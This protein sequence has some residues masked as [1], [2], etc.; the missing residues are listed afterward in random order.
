MSLQLTS[1]PKFLVLPHRLPDLLLHWLPPT[2]HGNHR[3]H[4]CD[5][6][7]D[8][9]GV[10][11]REVSA[12]RQIHFVLLLC[13]WD[14]IDWLLDDGGG[15]WWVFKWFLLI[16][17]VLIIINFSHLKSGCNENDNFHCLRNGTEVLDW[18]GYKLSRDYVYL[19]YL[20]MM[21]I[22]LIC[23]LVAYTGVRRYIRKAGFYWKFSM[24]VPPTSL[25]HPHPPNNYSIRH[26]FS[27]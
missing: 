13:K 15:N 1:S 10:H 21:T 27:I 12:L 20:G 22:S 25:P 26:S 16:I 3:A 7:A 9:W 18:A 14:D 2:D 19:D 4:W 17:V 11:Q 23:H 6:D 8:G 5:A 24:S